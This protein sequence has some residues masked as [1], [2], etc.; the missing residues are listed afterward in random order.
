M[1]VEFVFA[2]S[3]QLEPPLTLDC[4]LAIVPI[5]PVKVSKPLVLPVQTEDAPFTVPP[6]FISSTVTVVGDAATAAHTP[7]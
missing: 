4:H 3:V 5:F 6:I 2:M 7:L 1:Y